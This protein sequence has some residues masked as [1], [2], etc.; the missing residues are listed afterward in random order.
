MA[1]QGLGRKRLGS[2]FG[3]RHWIW[4]ISVPQTIRNG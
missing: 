1:V 2:I 4:V 3:A